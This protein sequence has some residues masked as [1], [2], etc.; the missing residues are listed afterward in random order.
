MFHGFRLD[1]IDVGPGRIR[2][3]YG[4][5]GS[6]VLLLHGHPRT[7]MTWGRVADMLADKHS[8]VCPDLPGFGRSYIPVD[9]PDSRHSSKRAKAA[10]LV[11]MMKVLGHDRFDVVGHDRGR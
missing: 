8:V 4:G 10:V 7:H 6:P 5:S 11:E 9:A 1:E 3:R 2:V